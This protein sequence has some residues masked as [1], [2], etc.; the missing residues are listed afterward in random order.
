MGTKYQLETIPV[1]DGIRSGSECFIC[2][3]MKQAEDDS[4][5]FYLGASVSPA[6]LNARPVRKP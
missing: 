1:W 6:Y 5:R 3:L 2:D 4:L